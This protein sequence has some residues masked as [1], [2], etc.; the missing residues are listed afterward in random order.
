M[1]DKSAI[2][3]VEDELISAYNLADNL[4]YLGYQVS[5][6]VNTG[7]EAIERI[8]QIAPD[9][10]IMDIELSGS[11]SGI[12]AANILRDRHVPVIFLTAFA[13]GT[14]LNRAMQSQPYGYLIK[15]AQLEN[16]QATLEVALTRTAQDKHIRHVID[17]ERHLNQLKSHFYTMLAHDLRTPLSIM[18]AS[19]ELVREYGEKLTEARKQQHFV[20]MRAA[21]REMTQQLESLMAAEQIAHNGLPYTPQWI[22]VIAYTRR[23]VSV[24]RD[25][26]QEKQTLKLTCPPAKHEIWADTALLGHILNN[27]LSNAIKYSP[28]GGHITVDLTIND[29]EVSWTITDTGIG[30]PENFRQNLFTPFER[31][32]NVE[33]TK[34]TGMGLYIVG[35]AIERH[36]G[37]IEV[38][39]QV[40]SGTT[41]TVRLPKM[42]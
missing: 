22:D 10:V 21:I 30:I 17:E 20:Q 36:Q 7:E 15:P 37:S 4:T 27:L 1:I 41:F 28:P 6:I 31:A 19:L 40:N 38:I 3:I 9:L 33:A 12:E 39:S 25:I 5:D 18:L 34:G 24:F 35:Q 8:E 26:L 32:D 23:R 16:I 42:R 2:L 13:D 11:L 14:V 29:Q